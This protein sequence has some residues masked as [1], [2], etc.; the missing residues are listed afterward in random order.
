MID[1]ETALERGQ[2]AAAADK[3]G[4]SGKVDQAAVV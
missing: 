1:S 2:F 4:N 3:I